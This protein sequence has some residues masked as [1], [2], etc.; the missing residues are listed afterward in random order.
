M[1][2]YRQCKPGCCKTGRGDTCYHRLQCACHVAADKAQ[3]ARDAWQDYI[4]DTLGK[5]AR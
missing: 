5:E 2:P 1:N 4:D 3:Q